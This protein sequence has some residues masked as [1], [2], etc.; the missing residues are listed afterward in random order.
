MALLAESPKRLTL[1]EWRGH[2]ACLSTFK[3]GLS[4]WEDPSA[5]LKVSSVKLAQGQSVRCP[6]VLR[7]SKEEAGQVDSLLFH[8]C[9]NLTNKIV[10]LCKEAWKILFKVKNSA[11]F[12]RRD[13]SVGGEARHKLNDL[14]SIS[15]APIA[16]KERTDCWKLFSDLHIH[17]VTPSVCAHEHTH[18]YTQHE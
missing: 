16:W 6:R 10:G 13:G 14:S 18:P 15:L 4:W 7:T 5:T 9:P 8:L 11:A 1:T 12:L 2:I 17:T 3:E